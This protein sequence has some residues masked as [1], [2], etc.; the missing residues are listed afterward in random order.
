MT[1][2]MYN[3]PRIFNDHLKYVFKLF[4]LRMCMPKTSKEYSYTTLIFPF[5][6]SLTKVVGY[7]KLT[8]SP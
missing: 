4:I 7:N 6:G 1:K 5:D 8:M 2:G 3:A